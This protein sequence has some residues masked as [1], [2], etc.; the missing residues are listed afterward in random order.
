MI[1][2]QFI[3]SVTAAV[4]L[5]LFAVRQVQKG[6]ESLLGGRMRAQMA[7][8]GRTGGLYVMG[9]TMALLMQSSLAVALLVAGFAVTGKLSVA[10][11]VVATMGADLGSA[12]VVGV[13]SLNMPFLGPVA[14]AVGGVLFLRTRKP[15]LRQIGRA[16]FAISLVLVSLDLLRAAVA[17]LSGSPLLAT[18]AGPMERDLVLSYVV[19][20]ALAFVM[21]SSVAA[22]LTIIALTAAGALPLL[23]AAAAVAGCNLGSALIP[24]WLLRNQEAAARQMAVTVVAIRF[25]VSIAALALISI[26]RLAWPEALYWPGEPGALIGFHLAINLALV[27][28]VPFMRPIVDVVASPR[29]LGSRGTPAATS[30]LSG[31]DLDLP[32]APSLVMVAVQREVFGL[33]ERV[34]RMLDAVA[35]SLESSDPDIFDTLAREER[36]AAATLDGLREF[37]FVADRDAFDKAD[38][39]RIKQRLEYAFSLRSAAGTIATTLA[40]Q[41]KAKA[42]AGVSFSAEGQQEIEALLR[43][44]TEN[45]SRAAGLVMSE[46]RR[47][48]HDLIEAKARVN[49]L[50]RS[51]RRRHLKRIG[52]RLGQS[53]ESS[54]LH[55]ETIRSLKEIGS[56]VASIGYAFADGS[57]ARRGK[58]ATE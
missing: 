21:H 20:V 22:I 56:L 36:E 29:L 46:D 44:V 28:A 39:R 52:R 40:K 49:K 35:R 10:G 4:M 3:L 43:G 51:S 5:L 12:F 32:G 38:W 57:A 8:S 18:I 26:D 50:Y 17:P 31:L 34:E 25:A 42:R 6:V 13:L 2:I 19:G 45:T 16:I 58:A 23:A 9:A 1:L 11:A 55:L 41:L 30:K 7:T 14:M 54:N 37:I 15:Q 47:A 33:V 24:L 53:I 48:A 27:F